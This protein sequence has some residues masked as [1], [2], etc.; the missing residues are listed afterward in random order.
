LLNY[1]RKALNGQGKIYSADISETAPAAEEADKSFLLPPIS[2]P[3][4]V[5]SLLD[6]CQ[7]H[8]VSAI[9]PLNDLELPLLAKNKELFEHHK[10][11]VLVSSYRVIDICFDKWKTH[12]FLL[13]QGIKN[14]ATYLEL[15][16]AI[17]ALNSGEITFPLAVKPRWGSASL[18][19]E[20]AEDLDELSLV[21][22]LVSK[23]LLRTPLADI[24]RSDPNHSVLIQK[25]LRGKEYGLDVI[26]DLKGKFVASISREKLAMRAGETDKART[27]FSTEFKE[28]GRKIGAALCHVGNL[29]CDV[30]RSKDSIYVLEMNPRFGGGY[31]FS[32]VA[33]A[34]VP[35]AIV[36]WLKGKHASPDCFSVSEGVVSVKY[37]SLV[38]FK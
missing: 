7:K 1:F 24:Y 6:I 36:M 34:D 11:K 12:L 31:P 30:F 2:A 33:G 29:D 23:K 19:V 32:H 4:Y 25:K 15:N 26:N 9:I 10:I 35:R 22:N 8:H 14:P 28:L 16:A 13:S 27:C 18:A 37:D 3:D 5:S 17:K 20:F 38:V 21:Y